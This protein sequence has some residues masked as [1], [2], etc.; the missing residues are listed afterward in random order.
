[1][2]SWPT[3]WH[4]SWASLRRRW[5]KSQ[6]HKNKHTNTNMQVTKQITNIQIQTQIRK[7]NHR[8]KI[9]TWA[10]K[11][12]NSTNKLNTSSLQCGRPHQEQ[13]FDKTLKIRLGE[14]RA[15]RLH[16]ELPQRGDDEVA[17]HQEMHQPVQQLRGAGWQP[18]QRLRR[19]Q[20]WDNRLCW[21]HHGLTRNNT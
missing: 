9:Q 19:G 16:G 13:D 8:H 18:A 15:C 21:V 4:A 3:S 17:V 1:M 14:E 10:H 2:E 6:I 20:Q 11:H 7:Y 12:K 5:D